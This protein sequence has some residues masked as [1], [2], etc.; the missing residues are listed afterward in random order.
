MPWGEKTKGQAGIT[1]CGR[2]FFHSE[3][4]FKLWAS[5]LDQLSFGEMPPP[6]EDNQPDPSVTAKV[7]EWINLRLEESGKAEAY[8]EKLLAPEYGNW[9]D[10]EKLFSGEIDTPPFSPSRLWRFSPE[11]FASSGFGKAKSPYTYVTSERGIRDYAAMSV[12]DQSTVQ[13]MTIVADSYIADRERRGEFKE[14]A[15][16]LPTPGEQVLLAR[17]SQ[18]FGRV[19]GRNPDKTEQEKYLAFLKQSIAKGWNLDGL[20][21]MVK[22]MFLSPNRSSGWNSAWGRS[23]NTVADTCRRRNWP[24]PSP[25]P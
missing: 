11:I 6:E 5:V 17:V 10:H 16:D 24:M 19:I 1:Q 25:T 14:F 13:M 21:T 12:V 4:S 7:V 15:D 3:A 18:E 2:R 20:K 9:V 23:T 8:R 22:A